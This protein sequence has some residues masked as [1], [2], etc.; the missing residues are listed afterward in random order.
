MIPYCPF[1]SSIPQLCRDAARLYYVCKKHAGHH[2]TGRKLSVTGRSALI[3][4]LIEVTFNTKDHLEGCIEEGSLVGV[5]YF[6]GK[7]DSE[8]E[9]LDKFEKNLKYISQHKQNKQEGKPANPD[10]IT[11]ADIERAKETPILSLIEQDMQLRKSGKDYMGTCPLHQDKS[12]SF[13][14]SVEKNIF[15]CFSCREGGGPIDYL[16]KIKGYEFIEAVRLL[17]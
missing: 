12:P 2:K 13:S 3:D 11:D 17:K 15:Y 10:R 5:V 8:I 4:R 14:V 9:T 1:P 6:K 7:L 16:I